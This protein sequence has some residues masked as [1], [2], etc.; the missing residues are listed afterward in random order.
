MT[1][2]TQSGNVSFPIGSYVGRFPIE[3][4]V[5]LVL[6]ENIDEYRFLRRSISVYSIVL[7]T[8][9]MVL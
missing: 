2:Y 7:T 5:Y 3:D 4:L 8:V 1:A 6:Q 9:I